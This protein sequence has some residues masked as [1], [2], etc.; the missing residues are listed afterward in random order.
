MKKFKDLNTNI[1]LS[2]VLLILL[3]IGIIV[4]WSV[5]KEEVKRGFRYFSSNSEQTDSISASE[6]KPEN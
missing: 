2:I 3:T 1:K 6:I 5:I 4:R